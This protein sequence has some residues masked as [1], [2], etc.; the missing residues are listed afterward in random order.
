[1][2]F[3][4][5]VNVWGHGIGAVLISP[6]GKHY[7]V[8]AKLIF[9]CT[10]NIAEYEACILGLQTALDWGV[11]RLTVK[12][13][14][15]LVIHQ[16][17]GEWETRN[18]KLVPYREFIQKMIEGFD[19]ISFSHTPRENNVISDA[20][21]TL[22]ALFKVEEGVRIETIQIRVQLEPAHS[23]VIEEADGKPWFYDI[24]TYIQKNQ[25]PEGAASNDRRTIRRL[26][27]G[28]FL[29]GEVLYK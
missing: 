15:A 27:M 19:S 3:D 14:S 16:L 1:M 5:A 9:P 17:T 25:Y 12:G 28:F 10:N 6:D 21:A 2:L 8:V 22:A 24:K 26:A 11:K 7:S 20:L 29:D 13:D 23:M 18:S 4:G